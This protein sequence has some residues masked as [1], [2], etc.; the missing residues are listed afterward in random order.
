MLRLLVLG[1][2]QAAGALLAAL[3]VCPL[4]AAL[5]LAGEC[6]R[7]LASRCPLKYVDER[8]TYPDTT[9]LGS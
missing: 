2:L 8:A 4:L 5:V 6:V 7:V 3:A 9:F 1:V